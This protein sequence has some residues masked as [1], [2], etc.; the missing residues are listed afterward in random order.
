[1]Y[2]ASFP[3]LF[4][5]FYSPLLCFLVW[6]QILS[7]T[8]LSALGQEYRVTQITRPFLFLT[9]KRGCNNLC[10]ALGGSVVPFQTLL[11]PPSSEAWSLQTSAASWSGVQTEEDCSCHL[12]RY[13]CF[14]RSSISSASQ[15]SCCA[16]IWCCDSTR[17][18]SRGPTLR[19]ARGIPHLLPNSL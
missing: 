3:G 6:N 16:S 14:G 7:T 11:S 19:L 1:M 2:V 17:W 9:V 10:K 18:R 15:T 5:Y 13:R 4:I 12:T 8:S